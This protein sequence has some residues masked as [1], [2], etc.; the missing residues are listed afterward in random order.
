MSLEHGY[1]GST[2]SDASIVTQTGCGTAGGGHFTCTEEFSRVGIP[3][4]P[5]F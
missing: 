2:P 4:G 3:D 5:K 1:L